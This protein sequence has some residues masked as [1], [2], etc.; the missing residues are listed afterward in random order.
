MFRQIPPFLFIAIL[1]ALVVGGRASTYDSFDSA[2]SQARALFDQKDYSAAQ[3]AFS[4]ALELAV[5]SDQRGR[6]RVGLGKCLLESQDGDGCR[7]LAEETLQD[8]SGQPHWPQIHAL[9]LIAGSYLREK[10]PD[11]M[12]STFDR[13]DE[14][15]GA[16]PEMINW[17]RLQFAGMLREEGFLDESLAMYG[18]VLNGGD[19]MNTAWALYWTVR[20]HRESGHR[21][22]ALAHLDRIREVLYALEG[23]SNN[24]IIVRHL[25]ATFAQLQGEGG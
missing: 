11:D 25:R 22:Q 19:T 16:S 21:D 13:I 1:G 17:L 10:R 18:E 23:G 9:H 8:V 20:I 14:V 4:A 15:A 6:A 3:E 24:E 5:D 7:K 12:Q 2:H